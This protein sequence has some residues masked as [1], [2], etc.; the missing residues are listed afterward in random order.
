MIK[1]DE[2]CTPK[3]D[4]I[5]ST[6]HENS[7]SRQGLCDIDTLSIVQSYSENFEKKESP[8]M[9]ELNPFSSNRK[10]RIIT[11]SLFAD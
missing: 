4:S 1:I 10:T 2:C 7:T 3:G 6:F 8:G 11:T 5:I 9:A